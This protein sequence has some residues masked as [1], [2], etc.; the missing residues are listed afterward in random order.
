MSAFFAMGGYAVYVWPAYG[1]AT[2]VIAVLVIE[3]VAS[4]RRAQRELAKVE[5]C[6]R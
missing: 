4:Y 6:R 1:V 3:S 5:R 2:V